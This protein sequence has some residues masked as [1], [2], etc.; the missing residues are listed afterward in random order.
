MLIQLLNI[1]IFINTVIYGTKNNREFEFSL[2][3]GELTIYQ[4]KDTPSDNLIINFS[5]ITPIPYNLE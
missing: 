3:Q 5:F 2:V 4:R 1:E